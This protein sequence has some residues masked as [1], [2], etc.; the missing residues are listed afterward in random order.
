MLSVGPASNVAPTYW[1][2]FSRCL[3]FNQNNIVFRSIIYGFLPIG[4]T[5]SMPFNL[6]EVIQMVIALRDVCLGII[7]LA[8]P[9]AKPTINDDYRL[10][11]KKV[12]IKSRNNTKEVDRQTRQWGYLFKVCTCFL[13]IQVPHCNSISAR[14]AF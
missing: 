6:L 9:D 1:T 12:G 7:E 8:Y 10:A 2:W 3:L 11:L 4:N 14:T 13:S 5:K